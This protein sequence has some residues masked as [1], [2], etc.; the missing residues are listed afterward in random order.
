MYESGIIR[1][2]KDKNYVSIH[3]GVF[4]NNRLTWAARGL[5]GYLLSKGDGW[6]MRIYDLIRQSSAGRDAVYSILR[7]LREC[8]YVRR[9][10]LSGDDGKFIWVTEVYEVAQEFEAEE[11]ASPDVGSENPS[12]SPLPAFPYMVKPEVVKPETVKPDTVEPDIYINKELLNTR[13]TNNTTHNTPRDLD[14]GDS[15]SEKP[16]CVSG[17][18]F[19]KEEIARY[20]DHCKQ[21]GQEIKGGL[22][23]WLENTA[24]GDHLVAAFLEREGSRQPKECLTPKARHPPECPQCFGSGIEVV[25][26]NG[27]RRCAWSGILPSDPGLP[28]GEAELE[29]NDPDGQHSFSST[30]GSF[31]NW[32]TQSSRGS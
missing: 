19:S 1:V 21:N 10:R 27:A 17:S 28:M 32:K 22:A 20:V 26:G 6:E 16:V 3:R 15:E 4:N 9:M 11:V 7:N 18:R 29:A 14:T 31:H 23:V 13:T 25:P 12:K 30:A 8:G 5:M 24:R 2:R